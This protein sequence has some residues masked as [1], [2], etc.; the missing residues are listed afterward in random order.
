MSRELED[1]AWCFDP[2]I[3]TVLV[4]VTS[5]GDEHEVDFCERHLEELLTGAR[6]AGRAATLPERR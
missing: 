1:C 3:A 6:P 5:R 2:A 4:Q